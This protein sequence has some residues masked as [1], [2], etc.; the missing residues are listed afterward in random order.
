M[1]SDKHIEMPCHSSNAAQD[2]VESADKSFRNYCLQGG[3]NSNF[4]YLANKYLWNTCA[5]WCEAYRI[6]EIWILMLRILL[7]KRGDKIDTQIA[8][9]EKVKITTK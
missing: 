9:T 7:F 2:N 6:N 8:V 1:G 5:K 3:Y 4:V